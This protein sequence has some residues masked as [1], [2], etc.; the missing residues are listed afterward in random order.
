MTKLN[1]LLQHLI[2][3]HNKNSA[4]LNFKA[5]LL[6]MVLIIVI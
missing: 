2:Y 1:L 5:I 4:I 6:A 3:E